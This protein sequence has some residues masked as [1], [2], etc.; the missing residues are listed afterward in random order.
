MGSVWYWAASLQVL[1]VALRTGLTYR[2]YSSVAMSMD[3]DLQRLSRR[4]AV[5]QHI[6]LAIL[7]GQMEFVG[8]IRFCALSNG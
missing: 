8:S 6:V 7:V 1:L 4:E 5:W 3:E 2:V